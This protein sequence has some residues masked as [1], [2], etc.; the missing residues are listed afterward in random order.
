MEQPGHREKSQRGMF[1]E[2]VIPATASTEFTMSAAG[3]KHSVTAVRFGVACRL[4]AKQ[5]DWERLKCSFKSMAPYGRTA[6]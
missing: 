1:R 3:Q 4:Q 5:S 6:R 2:R